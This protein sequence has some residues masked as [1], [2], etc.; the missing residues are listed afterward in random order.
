[1]PPHLSLSLASHFSL[2][3]PFNRATFVPFLCPLI[4][5]QASDES[6]H[7]RRMT[8]LSPERGYKFLSLLQVLRPNLISVLPEVV[9]PRLLA[10]RGT[11]SPWGEVLGALGS[12]FII[13][14]ITRCRRRGTWQRR[15]EV[16]NGYEPLR[17]SCTVLPAGFVLAF[18]RLRSPSETTPSLTLP[19]PFL[20]TQFLSPYAF[21]PPVF[22]RFPFLFLFFSRILPPTP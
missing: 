16:M 3:P 5:S 10:C 2:F 1:M 12:I 17:P 9:S 21:I 19:S 18:C 6:P 7:R 20:L 15:P 4:R 8:V 14:A 11:E 13:P 22:I